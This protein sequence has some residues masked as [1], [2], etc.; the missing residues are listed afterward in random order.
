MSIFRVK[1]ILRMNTKSFPEL[2]E[3]VKYMDFIYRTDFNK[4]KK[5]A[6]FYE[7]QPFEYEEDVL[8]FFGKELV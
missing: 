2:S 5:M 4:F 7:S 3:I 8:K 1:A 6:K